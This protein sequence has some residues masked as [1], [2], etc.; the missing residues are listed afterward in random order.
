[1]SMCEAVQE[2]GSGGSGPHPMGEAGLTRWAKR[3]SPEP[4]WATDGRPFICAGVQGE[5]KGPREVDKRKRG[6]IE[7]SR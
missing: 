5:D 7:V 4:R 6:E 1:M 3:A 2:K